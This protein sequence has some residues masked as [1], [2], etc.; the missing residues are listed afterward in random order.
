MAVKTLIF[1]ID[2]LYSNL[3][4]YYDLE[5]RIGNLEIIG[6]GRVFQ[7]PNLNFPRLL[8]KGVAYGS[9]D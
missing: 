3:K 9:F 5:A 7:V 4:P 1:G 8:N 6:Y 2:D